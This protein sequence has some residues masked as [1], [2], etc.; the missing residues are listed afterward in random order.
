MTVLADDHTKMTDSE[1]IQRCQLGDESSFRLVYQ[2]YRHKVRATLFKLCG[3][4]ILDDLTQEVFL[5]AWKALPKL[6]E[7]RYFSTWL[8]RI[9][10]NVACDRRKQL[11][12]IRRDKKT[13]YQYA[14]EVV[15][16]QGQLLQMHYQEIVQQGLQNLKMDHRVVLVLHDLEDL[17][18]KEIAEILSIPV[19]TVKSRL[20]NA[21]KA[22]RKFL[23]HQGVKI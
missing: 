1:L 23:E 12:K 3:Q 7:S 5:K 6:R 9:C 17:P 19:G 10:W 4:E 22:M 18:Q 13:L 21:R 11:A 15:L 20:F 16:D 2:R 14:P 8:Y